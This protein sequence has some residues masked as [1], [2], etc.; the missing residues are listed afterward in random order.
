MKKLTLTIAAM[1]G[2]SLGAYAQ[3]YVSMTDQD[4]PGGVNTNSSSTGASGGWTV[5]GQ[6][7]TLAIWM[8][9]S[10]STSVADAAA[11]SAADQTSGTAA[12]ALLQSDS[13]VFTQEL[14]GSGEGSLTLAGN[15]TGEGYFAL[16]TIEIQGVS[17]GTPQLSSVM[18]IVMTV[19]NNE[20]VLA[21]PQG[22]GGSTAP[23]VL[24]YWPSQ[25]LLLSPVPEPASL[26]LAGLGGLSMLLFRR[27]NK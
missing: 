12:I 17:G 25:N 7:F 15:A 2:L 21:F 14:L 13:S 23:G 19:G 10:N 24:T 26:A 4:T 5:T 20:G 8:A 3:G 11:I 18:A 1:I 9:A 16:G 22:L 27:R 6:P